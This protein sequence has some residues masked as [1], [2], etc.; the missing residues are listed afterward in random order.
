MQRQAGAGAPY[1]YIYIYI[2][3]YIHTYVCMYVCMHACKYVCMLCVCMYV[4]M[5]VHT[6]THTHSLTH[7]SI[8]CG[9][10]EALLHQP[11]AP[12]TQHTH[13]HTHT[14]AYCVEA[15]RRSCTSLRLHT[16]SMPPYSLPVFFFVCVLGTSVPA[17]GSTHTR[18][19][20]T[21]CPYFFLRNFL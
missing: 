2:H 1:I 19:R 18:C 14:P 5:Y 9:C 7:T 4:C 17:C 15:L 16:Y 20:R 12:H 21:L 3:T 13:T 8:L 10:S 6:H 11:A